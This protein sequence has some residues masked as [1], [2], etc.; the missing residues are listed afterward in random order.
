MLEGFMEGPA[1][2]H[3][4][5]YDRKESSRVLQFSELQHRFLWA[6]SLRGLPSLRLTS[7]TT[8]RLGLPADARWVTAVLTRSGSKAAL[9]FWPRSRRCCNLSGNL[10]FQG[11]TPWTGP[12]QQ[13]ERW[14]VTLCGIALERLRALRADEAAKQAAQQYQARLAREA[15]EAQLAI[16]RDLASCIWRN[17]SMSALQCTSISFTKLVAELRMRDLAHQIVVSYQAVSRAP[18]DK[19]SGEWACGSGWIDEMGGS[20]ARNQNH[21]CR[22]L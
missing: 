12:R 7:A 18:S 2:Q 11:S 1:K 6:N 19:A 14:V 21:G 10:G 5:S 8:T 22:S 3:I 16:A 20:A 9:I 13:S 17:F 15:G 4:A